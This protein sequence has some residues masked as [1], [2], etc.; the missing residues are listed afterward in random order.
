MKSGGGFKNKFIPERRGRGQNF[1]QARN[2]KHGSNRGQALKRGGHH[3]TR[4]KNVESIVESF[5]GSKN[6]I[7]SGLAPTVTLDDLK[8]LFEEFGGRPLIKIFHNEAGKPIGSAEVTFTKA[9]QV[10]EA[11]KTYNGV[12]LDGYPLKMRVTTELVSEAPIQLRQPLGDRLDQRVQRQPPAKRSQNY[13]R[14]QHHDRVNED[15][16]MMPSKEDL[17][18][19][20]EEYMKKSKKIDF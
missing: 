8:E 5:S 6:L 19:E 18:T 2:T 16:T 4:P 14:K 1:N 3:F 9:S 12:P 15:V 17:N 20:I 11:I 7:V 13:Q 10:A